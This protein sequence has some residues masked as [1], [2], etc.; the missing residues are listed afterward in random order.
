MPKVS[1]TR[2]HR[3]LELL[4]RLEDG[5]SFSD[6]FGEGMTTEEATKQFKIWATTWLIP[7]VKDLVL[8]LRTMVKKGEL[9]R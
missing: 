6:I 2:N 3:A 5:P 4:Q 9:D 1:N 7:E 8:E